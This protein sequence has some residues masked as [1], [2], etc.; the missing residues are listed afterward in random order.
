MVTTQI[1]DFTYRHFKNAFPFKMLFFKFVLN[2]IKLDV[3]FGGFLKISFL[4]FTNYNINVRVIL[5][6]FSQLKKFTFF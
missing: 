5:A 6:E 2:N 4:Q 1:F 3:R